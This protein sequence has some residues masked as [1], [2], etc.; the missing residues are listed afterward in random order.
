MELSDA[1]RAFE[2]FWI[3]YGQAH[4]M[5]MPILN[6]QFLFHSIRKWRFDYAHKDSMTAIEIDGGVWEKRKT[7]HT[8]G[9]GYTSDREKDNA[10]IDAGWV[11]RRYTPQAMEEDP[12]K[13]IEQILNSI[14]RGTVNNH[15]KPKTTE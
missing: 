14:R 13:C 15:V 1:E 11:V 7:G 5:D 4:D 2:T 10:A 9:V 3:M 8:S 12:F 6:G